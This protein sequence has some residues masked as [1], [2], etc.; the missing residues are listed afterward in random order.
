MLC[1]A[2]A[3]L[4]V[5]SMLSLVLVSRRLTLSHCTV[6]QGR[7][8]ELSHFVLAAPLLRQVPAFPHTAATVH[9][10]LVELCVCKVDEVVLVLVVLSCS[11]RETR[12]R[13]ALAAPC[14]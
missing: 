1:R 13:L 12:V 10:L 6:V 5:V 9:H 4:L 14:H 11:C 2:V 8:A 7:L 3:Y